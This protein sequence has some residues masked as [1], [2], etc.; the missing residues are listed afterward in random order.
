MNLL[1][2]GAA[3]QRVKFG[4]VVGGLVR[5]TATRKPPSCA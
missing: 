2:R 3:K 5:F 4:L 1:T